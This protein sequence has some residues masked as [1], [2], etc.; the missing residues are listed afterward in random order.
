MLKKI[1][2]VSIARTIVEF[3]SPGKQCRIH[4]HEPGNVL[5]HS[6][7]PLKVNVPCGPLITTGMQF[8]FEKTSPPFF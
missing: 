8:T 6:F 2:N 5:G 7:Q 1:F 3:K 4:C